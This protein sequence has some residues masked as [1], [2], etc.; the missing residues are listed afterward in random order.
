M[1]K[2]RVSYWKASWLLTEAQMDDLAM[3][4]SITWGGATHSLYPAHAIRAWFAPQRV[5]S[6]EVK[7][8]D[9]IDLET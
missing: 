1:T 9:L 2:Q 6:E 3:S 7:D 8:S 5:I 4:S